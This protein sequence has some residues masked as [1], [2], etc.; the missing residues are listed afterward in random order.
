MGDASYRV[1]VAM[2][3]T[4]NI[5]ARIQGLAGPN[6]VLVSQETYPLVQGLFVSQSLGA[7]RLKG[8][9]HPVAVY[10]IE[11][12]SEAQS[13]FEVAVR[14]GLTPAESVR[15]QTTHSRIQRRRTA[16]PCPG[17]ARKTQPRDPGR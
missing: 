16:S 14:S 3:Q 10:R 17:S 9:S 6:E 13:R 5:A 7:Q 8:V 11:A 4:P 12:E 2:G 15:L 1:E